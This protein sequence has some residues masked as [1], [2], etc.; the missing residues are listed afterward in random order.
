MFLE[1]LI[2]NH[3]TYTIF[4]RGDSNVNHNNT[5]RMKIFNNFLSLLNLKY[6]NIKHRTYHHFVGD[7]V[8]D[9][10]IDVVLHSTESKTTEQ[11]SE[12]ICGKV[13]PLIESHHDLIVSTF[14]LPRIIPEAT[15]APPSPPIIANTRVRTMWSDEN[16]EPYKDLINDNLEKLRDRWMNPESRTSVSILLEQTSSILKSAA[17]ATNKSIA[18]ADPAN[19]VSKRI[20]RTIRKS[21]LKLLKI[22][23]K[24]KSLLLNGAFNN[25]DIR[26]E[27]KNEKIKIVN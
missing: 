7:G 17:M 23:K 20:P 2:D 9:S 25:N 5:I 24:S 22:S 15:K 4:I 16:I 6:I 26:K 13:N 8:F 3:P 10:N 11:I 18:L 21:H 19:I 27:I 14:A 1:D 12:I